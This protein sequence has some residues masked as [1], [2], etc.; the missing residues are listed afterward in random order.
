M[1][2]CVCVCVCV[3]LCV[4]VSVCVCVKVA[5]ARE[6][7]AGARLHPLAPGE[8]GCGRLSAWVCEG[9]GGGGGGRCL[10]YGSHVRVGGGKVGLDAHGLQVGLRG[11]G[12]QGGGAR[13]RRECA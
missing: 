10:V 5:I 2:V 4:S 9:G 1:C 12:R 8:G 7:P 13:S 3:C 6:N 11:R